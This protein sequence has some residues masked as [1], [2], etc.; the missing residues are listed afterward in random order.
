MHEGK[1][2]AIEGETSSPGNNSR[3]NSFASK[4]KPNYEMFFTKGMFHCGISNLT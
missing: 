2:L 3:L 1:K 4:C